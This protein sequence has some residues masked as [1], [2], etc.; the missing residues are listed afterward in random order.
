MA[1]EATR[2][3]LEELR[4]INRSIVSRFTIP[5]VNGSATS[6]VYSLDVGTREGKIQLVR[7]ASE[8]GA[9]YTVSFKTYEMADD[10]SVDNILRIENINTMGYQEADLNISYSNEDETQNPDPDDVYFG[11]ELD[12]LYVQVTNIDGS[13]TGEITVELVIEAQD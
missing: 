4:D 1:T 9:N 6:V 11:G 8:S 3:K 12:L 13:A 10:Y 5:S 2:I 7:I